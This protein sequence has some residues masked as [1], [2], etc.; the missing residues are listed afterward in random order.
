LFGFLSSV[1][2]QVFMPKLRFGGI[3]TLYNLETKPISTFE[4]I[5]DLIS[6]ESKKGKVAI[7]PK[8]DTV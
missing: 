3:L 5:S 7:D 4:A 2:V 8:T 1:T 6:L